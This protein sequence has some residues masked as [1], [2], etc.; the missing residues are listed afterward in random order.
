MYIY[1]IIDVIITIINVLEF[2]IF[3]LDAP[4]TKNKN[5]I[6]ISIKSIDLISKFLVNRDNFFDKDDI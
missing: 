1:T 3:A 5:P 4:I 2:I 6:L